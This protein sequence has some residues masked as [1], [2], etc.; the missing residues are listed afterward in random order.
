LSGNPF[1]QKC[2]RMMTIGYRVKDELWAKLPEPWHS[3]SV[4][5]LEC[6]CFEL[7]R[8]NPAQKITLNDFM[9]LAILGDYDRNDFGGTLIDCEYG[10]DGRLDIRLYL[11]D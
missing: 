7:E 2:L 9:F 11:S 4:L 8:A 6:F 1:C 10:I 5:C 3:G